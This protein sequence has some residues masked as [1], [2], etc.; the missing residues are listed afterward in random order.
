MVTASPAAVRYS[1]PQYPAGA[2]APRLVA[3]TSLS[4]IGTAAR[5]IC[6]LD[7]TSSL[8][9]GPACAAA[10]ATRAVATATAHSSGTWAEGE[11]LALPGPRL[12]R[13]AWGSTSREAM[14]SK[15]ARTPKTALR[16][17]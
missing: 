10:A 3:G 13:V 6:E 9:D 14:T 12:W 11:D 16:R 7:G 1:P 15:V 2:T 17:R 8:R 5:E 4:T